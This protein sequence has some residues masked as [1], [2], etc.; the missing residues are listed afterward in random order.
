MRNL[1]CVVLLSLLA[2][3]CGDDALKENKEVYSAYNSE[4]EQIQKGKVLFT[5]NCKV[6]HSLNPETPT[7]MAPV[8]Q[9]LNEHWPDKEL[10]ARH[11][12]NA[13]DMLQSNEHTR[14]MYKEWK[15]K[16]LMPPFMGLSEQEIQH[17]IAYLF[18]ATK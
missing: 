14:A 17:I 18:K 9:N 5:T 15:D 12:K 7:G 3:A 11:I 8:L 13:P 10:L 2:F 4:E 16:A 6:C 1:S